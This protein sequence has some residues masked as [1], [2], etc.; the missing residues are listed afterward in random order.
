MVTIERQRRPADAAARA[1]VGVLVAIR[2]L[3]DVM[4]RG[5]RDFTAR[6]VAPLRCRYPDGLS[7]R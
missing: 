3:R 6:Q 2:R 4:R 1:W 7:T 5:V